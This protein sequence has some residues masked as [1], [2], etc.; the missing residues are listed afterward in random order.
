MTDLTRYQIANLMNRP[1]LLW[2]V[3]LDLS[4]ANLTGVNLSGANV[5]GTLMPDGKKHE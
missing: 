4:G 3:G 5:T 1:G 2:L